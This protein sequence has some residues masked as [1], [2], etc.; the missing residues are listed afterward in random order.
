MDD[1][2]GVN[3][4]AFLLSKFTRYCGPT[5]DFVARTSLLEDGL[6]L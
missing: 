4:Q 5:C 2:L 3:L 1:F 6:G